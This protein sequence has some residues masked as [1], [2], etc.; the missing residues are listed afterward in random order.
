MFG[1]TSYQVD[2]DI[3]VI[4]DGY[5]EH[6]QVSQSEYKRLLRLFDSNKKRYM[7]K[8]QRIMDTRGYVTASGESVLSASSVTAVSYLTANN[9][10]SIVHDSFDFY[11]AGMSWLKEYYPNISSRVKSRVVYE[12]QKWLYHNISNYK[13]IPNGQVYRKIIP[14]VLKSANNIASAVSVAWLGLEI[15]ESDTI[16]PSDG[17]STVVLLA[18]FIPTVGPFIS[19][20][21]ATADIVL[22]SVTDHS[23]GDYFDSV[24]IDET[25]R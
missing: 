18:G 16:K 3:F 23:I 2:N 12:T 7:R 21:Y 13:R 17:L 5:D 14:S 20:G 8:R 10:Q 15:L 6:L 25:T 9:S 22:I 1:L 24:F 19:G 11:G 4:D